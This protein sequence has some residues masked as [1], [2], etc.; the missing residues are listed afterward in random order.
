LKITF[1]GSH[2]IGKTT[3]ASYLADVLGYKLVRLEIIDEIVKLRIED[4]LIRQLLFITHYIR[5]F[6]TS[7]YA[8]NN[9][10]YDSHPLLV[11]SYCYWWY[12]KTRDTKLK[13][14]IKDLLNLLNYL[15]VVDVGIVLEA[16]DISVVL[17]RIKHRSRANV[18]EEAEAEYVKFIDKETKEIVK[19]KHFLFKEL[20]FVNGCLELNDR[21]KIILSKLNLHKY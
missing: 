12:H 10:I 2:G 15:P 18:D 16:K 17:D 21:C 14:F 3:T 11:L 20:L 6:I 1:L 13:E 19:H 9:I 8:Y 4:K 7:Y 5:D